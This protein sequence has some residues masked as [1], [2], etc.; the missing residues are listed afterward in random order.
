MRRRQSTQAG[1]AA[2]AM[3]IERLLIEHVR[4]NYLPRGTEVRI[5]PEV[6]LFDTGILDS[7]AVLSVILFIETE[8]GLTIPDE[9]LLPENISSVAAATRYITMRLNGPDPAPS[10]G[11]KHDVVDEEVPGLG[12]R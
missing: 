6:N 7:A 11:V 9:D 5:D 4:E 1:S 3:D 10:A 8:F 12:S 2:V